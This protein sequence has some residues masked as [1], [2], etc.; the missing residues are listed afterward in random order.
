MGRSWGVEAA[1]SPAAVAVLVLLAALD[2]LL[3]EAHRGAELRE[4]HAY[5]D[6]GGVVVQLGDGLATTESPEIFELLGGGRRCWGGWGCWRGWGCWG[7]R[8]DPW[9]GWHWRALDHLE[10]IVGEL[11]VDVEPLS[12][13]F[14]PRVFAVPLS[15]TEYS[16]ELILEARANNGIPYKLL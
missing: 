2:R 12:R 10:E 5:S 11:R 6:P 13:P 16:T 4:N 14:G 7:R 8:S 15:S 9:V 3:P 1:P